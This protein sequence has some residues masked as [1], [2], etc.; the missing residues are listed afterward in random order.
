MKLLEGRLDHRGLHLPDHVEDFEV[1]LCGALH[2]MVDASDPQVVDIFFYMWV[3]SR[4]KTMGHLVGGALSLSPP[5]LCRRWSV[6]SGGHAARLH[7]QRRHLL[8]LVHGKTF[9]PR[10]AYLVGGLFF[11]QGLEAVRSVATLP[12]CQAGG[13]RVGG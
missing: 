11:P 9:R 13:F 7:L 8:R 3:F 1:D 10:G 6:W 12:T 5:R 2:N 4:P